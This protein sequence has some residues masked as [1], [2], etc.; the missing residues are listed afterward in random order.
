MANNH[1]CV[2]H[3]A[4]TELSVTDSIPCRS[5]STVGPKVMTH[6]REDLIDILIQKNVEGLSKCTL[7][8]KKRTIKV[9]K[10][11]NTSSYVYYMWKSWSPVE[12]HLH[13][14]AK[15]AF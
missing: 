10:L 2:V 15:I 7:L 5:E 11:K 8:D 13:I 14:P 4:E 9:R 12:I 1:V 3:R 6:F